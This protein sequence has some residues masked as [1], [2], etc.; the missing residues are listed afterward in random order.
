MSIKSF[1]DAHDFWP[2]AA[3][4]K[5]TLWQ[6]LKLIGSAVAEG[7]AASHKYEELRARG[8]PHA[9]AAQRAVAHAAD[10]S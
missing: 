2:I 4:P 7:L 3:Q 10:R 1:D 9:I 6:S 5:F 8:I